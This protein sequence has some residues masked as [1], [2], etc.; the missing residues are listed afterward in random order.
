M[1]ALPRLLT[2]QV[3]QVAFDPVT[4]YPTLFY[5]RRGRDVFL[6]CKPH[7]EAVEYAWDCGD[8]QACKEAWITAGGTWSSLIEEFVPEQVDKIYLSPG[9]VVPPY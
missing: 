1:K 5:E 6:A 4:Y 3:L 8:I 2:G 9:A 7:F